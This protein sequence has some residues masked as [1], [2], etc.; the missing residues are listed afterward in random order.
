A[1]WSQIETRRAQLT[2]QPNFITEPVA[3]YPVEETHLPYDVVVEKLHI[4]LPE[5]KIP[6]S[7]AQN[8]HIVDEQLGIGGPKQKFARNVEAIR[9]LQT[10]ESENRNAT[11]EEQ[12]I[13][14]QYVGWGGL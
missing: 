1:L 7:P 6:A 9:T 8:F 13:L 2:A 14:S 12:E 3:A 4:E 10:L 5:Q 11:P